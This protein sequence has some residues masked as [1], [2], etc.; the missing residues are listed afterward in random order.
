MSESKKKELDDSLI[1]STLTNLRVIS[2]IKAGDKLWYANNEVHIDDGVQLI[3][4]CKRWYLQ[5]DR[6]GTIS[7]L[8]NIYKNAFDIINLII[9]DGKQSI[10]QK[11]L[12][13]KNIDIL[14]EFIRLLE[15][16]IEGLNLLK[17]T[18]K[19]DEFTISKLETLY[20]QIIYQKTYATEHI[21]ITH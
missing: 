9:N 5:Y 2:K 20:K 16:S 7:T 4:G 3:Q 18:Y 19:D 12:N 6:N 1:N 14:Q 11:S 8:E 13:Y 15:S 17:N 21:N 10:N